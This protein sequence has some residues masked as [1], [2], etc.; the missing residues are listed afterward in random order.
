MYGKTAK[1]L[2]LLM[3]AIR[4]GDC[5]NPACEAH[6]AMQTAQPALAL[7]VLMHTKLLPPS[8]EFIVRCKI[9]CLGREE[10]V[11]DCKHWQKYL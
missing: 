8:E 7:T 4:R 10:S 5:N 6:N 2:T 1:S 11:S 3:L 9:F